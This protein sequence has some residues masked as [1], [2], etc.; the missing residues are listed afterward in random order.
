V[1]FCHSL[2]CELFVLL[3]LINTMLG[4]RNE[5]SDLSEIAELFVRNAVTGRRLLL[6]TLDNLRDMGIQSVGHAVE[7]YVSC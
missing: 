6:L 1:H 2:C 4:H 7:I 5:L 3:L